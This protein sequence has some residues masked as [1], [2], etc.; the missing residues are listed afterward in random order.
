[1][2]IIR[3][4]I[5]V[6][7]L[8]A[9]TRQAPGVAEVALTADEII[10][11]YDVAVGPIPARKIEWRS[12]D[13]EYTRII[14]E[15]REGKDGPWKV[16]LDPSTNISGQRRWM[17][18]S[19]NPERDKDGKPNKK[20]ILDIRLGFQGAAFSGWTGSNVLIGAPEPPYNTESSLDPRQLFLLST[21]LGQIRVRMESSEKKFSAN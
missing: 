9:C 20:W 4:I 21:N 7:F 11:V 13:A 6:L 3:A 19:F 8:A 5:P 17:I 16:I 15:S 10:S 12:P 18:L 14:V 2:R 1:M